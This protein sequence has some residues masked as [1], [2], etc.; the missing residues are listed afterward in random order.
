MIFPRIM[1]GFLI[2]KG[3]FYETSTCRQ[4]YANMTWGMQG[5]AR[6]A[7]CDFDAFSSFN[8][9]LSRILTGFPFCR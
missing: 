2:G 6:G 7:F 4:G 5:G 1:T 3:S 8:F 9:A